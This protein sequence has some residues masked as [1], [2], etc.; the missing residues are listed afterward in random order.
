MLQKVDAELIEICKEIKAKN[1]SLEKWKMADSCDM[2]QSKHYCGGFD[3]D[4]QLF[5]FSYF[6]N[7]NKESYFKMDLIDVVNIINGSK[8]AL[9]LEDPK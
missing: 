6:D 4:D 9:V 3:A 2:F 1:Y 7:D 5:W 8:K